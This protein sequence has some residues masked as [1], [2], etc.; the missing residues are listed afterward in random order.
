VQG[1]RRVVVGVSG[2]VASLAALRYGVTEVRGNGGALC[3]V[4]AWC[5]PGGEVGGR[6]APPR[7]LVREWERSAERRLRTAFDETFGGV[8]V[9]VEIRL[10]VL[11]GR[12]A[13][14]LTRVAG[15]GSDLLVIGSR[16][17]WLRSP[18]AVTVAG[19]C[20]QH[21]CCPVVVAPMAPLARL[22]GRWEM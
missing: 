17:G 22:A 13:P 20:A 15:L 1:T 2:S 11:R 9:D 4:L 3:A 5:P 12:P 7:V 14:M 18:W 10:L 16:R 6:S 21:A 8:P 19:Q